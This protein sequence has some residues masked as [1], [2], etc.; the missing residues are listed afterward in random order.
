[1]KIY[2]ASRYSR[3]LEMCDYRLWLQAK[4][5]IVTGRWLNG[6][7]QISTTGT[8]IG[9]NGEALVEG[10]DGS[11]DVRAA[12]LRER[13]AQDDVEDVM[14]ADLVISFTESPRGAPSNR[15]GRHVEFGIALAMDKWLWIV[16]HRE[17][18]FHWLPTVQFFA[19]WHAV[20][21]SKLFAR[22]EAAR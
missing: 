6:G 19:D 8:P 22:Q 5:Y 7:H 10:D 4:G 9:E 3:R 21:E 18:I 11:T 1:M 20:T 12:E 17:N 16:G 15:G 2:L 14:A 13:F